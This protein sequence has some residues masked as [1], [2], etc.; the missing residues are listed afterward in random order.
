[1]QDA[2]VTYQ[3]RVTAN[4]TNFSGLGLFKFAI[5][6]STN[7]SHT[8]TGTATRNGQFITAYSVTIGG[9]GYLIAPA[10]TV[11]GGGGFGATATASISGGVVTAINAVN[12]G[13]GYT[14]TP[15]V[16]V[17]PP[18][19]NINYTTYRSNDGTSTVGSEPADA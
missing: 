7:N 6:T 8:A 9:N 15:T 19:V 18:T 2:V 5:V 13:S 12:A 1:A 4:G 17:A 10:V 11:T 16:T 14:S 3:G